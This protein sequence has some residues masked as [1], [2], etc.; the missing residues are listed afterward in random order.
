MEIVEDT[1]AACQGPVVVLL[2][3]LQVEQP[4][5]ELV[6]RGRGG[7]MTNILSSPAPLLSHPRTELVFFISLSSLFICCCDATAPAYRCIED[8]WCHHWYKT[9]VRQNCETDVNQWN[10]LYM[11]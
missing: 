9:D 3:T 11:S 7:L 1:V 6:L 8:D 5:T 2:H 4:V 10:M